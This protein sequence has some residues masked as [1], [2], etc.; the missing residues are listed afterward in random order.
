[1]STYSRQGKD[2]WSQKRQDDPGYDEG[3]C[4]EVL[5]T[6]DTKS[7]SQVRIRLHATR[8]VLH[9]FL[10]RVVDKFPFI[11]RNV[12]WYIYFVQVII[13]FKVYL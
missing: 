4:V 6:F 12:V 9:I 10:G 5:G 1:M 8:I 2:Y 3:L 7:E 13:K 11:A